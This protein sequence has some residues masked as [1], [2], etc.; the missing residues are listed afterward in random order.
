[1]LGME[2]HKANFEQPY[3]IYKKWVPCIAL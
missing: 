2:R 1:L 3:Y